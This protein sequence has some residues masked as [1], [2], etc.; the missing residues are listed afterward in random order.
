MRKTLMIL[1]LLIPAALAWSQTGYN[2]RSMGMAGAYQGISRGAEVS[3]WNP[4]NLALPDRPGITIDFLNF[5][6]SL[7]NNAFN[8]SLYNEYF[9]KGYFDEH[10]G[11]DAAAKEAILAE[12]PDDGIRLFNRF[13]VT[14]LAGSYK[15]FAVALNSFMYTDLKLPEDV[16]SIPLQGL[17]HEAA[18]LTDVEGE[19]IIGTE[20]TASYGRELPVAWDFVETLTVGGTLKLLWGQM[21]AV[22][23]DAGGKALS[24]SDSIGV[25]GSYT[26]F[27]VNPYDDKG[28]TGHG[29]AI[30]LGAATIVNDK[31]SV[32]LTLNNVIGGIGFKGCEV[33]TGEYSFHEPGLDQDQF[34]NLE[35][36]IDSS[37]TDHY[38]SD[39]KLSYR[40]PASFLLSGTYKL[41]DNVMIEG[42]YHQGLNNTAGGGTTPRLAVGSELRYLDW[43]PVRFGLAL[44]GIQGSTLAFG[45]GIDV[46]AYKLDFGIAGQRGLFNHS[47]GINFAM[48]Q[49]IQF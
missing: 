9:S 37:S 10:D 19:F 26:A 15:E 14:A 11:W 4:A 47:K 29:V 16:V 49:R 35:N 21:Y 6:T 38:A 23:D 1:S 8:I 3:L 27:L 31:L 25:E 40:L 30:D 34:D 12:V 45:F 48:S 5:G 46:G 28:E 42:D 39:R 22:L 41:N 44:G 33:Y 20:L 24:N 13:H 32:G 43:L 36:Y 2:A 7:G 17:G 18:D